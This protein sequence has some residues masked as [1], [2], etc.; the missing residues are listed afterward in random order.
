MV[1]NVVV[2]VAI[3]SKRDREQKQKYKHAICAYGDISGCTHKGDF[4]LFVV[5]AQISK[6][7]ENKKEQQSN[8]QQRNNTIILILE[9]KITETASNVYPPFNLTGAR[10]ALI[11]YY[12]WIRNQ[13]N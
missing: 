5:S 12:I 9:S 2:S 1:I 13:Q 4:C 7:N 10:G 8:R 6:T 3:A 11:F